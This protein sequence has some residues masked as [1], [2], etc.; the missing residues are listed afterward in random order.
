MMP[1]TAV[2]LLNR[3]LLQEFGLQPSDYKEFLELVAKGG[4]LGE[5]G[6]NPHLPAMGRHLR[7][8]TWSATTY[9]KGD[10]VCWVTAGSRPGASWADVLFGDVYAGS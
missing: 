2:H 5:S 1:A 3:G 4:A 8:R 9:S 7:Q 6:A 10:K